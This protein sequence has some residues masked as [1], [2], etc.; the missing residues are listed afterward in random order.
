G[1]VGAGK[2]EILRYLASHYKSRIIYTDAVAN[3]IKKKGQPC[4]EPVVALLGEEVLGSDGEIDKSRMAQKIF[5]DEALLEAVNGILH[6]AVFDYVTEAI[7]VERAAGENEFLFVEAAL[8]IEAGYGKIVDEM[9]YVFARE[10]VRRN[11]LKESRGYDDEKIDRIF[12]QQLTQKAFEEGADFIIDN[13]GA[14]QDACETIA[15]H[16]ETLRK[17]KEE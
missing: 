3:E 10:D 9:W 16:I 12:A 2:S 6:P 1:G 11:R 5:S 4:F 17:G 7:R 14:L 8:L 13:S 15:E